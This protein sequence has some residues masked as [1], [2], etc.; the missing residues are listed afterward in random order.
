MHG[1]GIL[2]LKKQILFIKLSKMCP[3]RIYLSKLRLCITH[4]LYLKL[5]ILEP[6]K[7]LYIILAAPSVK[8]LCTFGA[9]STR[10]FDFDI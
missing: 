9:I 1:Y 4:L 8:K 5:R 10:H 3:L 6:I 2:S 7:L